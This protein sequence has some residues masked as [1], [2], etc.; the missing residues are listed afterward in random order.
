M[1]ATVKNQIIE[2]INNMNQ[3]ELVELN[4]LYCQSANIYDNE[5]FSND[6][7]FFAMFFPNAGDGLKV[8]Q[9][10]F[11]GDYNYSHDWVTFN[12]YGNLQSYGYFTTDELCELVSV[13][14]EYIEENPDDFSSLINID[15]LQE[16]EE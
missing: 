3:N 2:L 5:V 15:E 12:G 8:A 10:V 1:K 13:I 6:E 7:E 14:A 9:A 16:T 11:Y 4:N